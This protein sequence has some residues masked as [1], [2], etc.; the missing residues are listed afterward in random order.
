MSLVVAIAASGCGSSKKTASTAATQSATPTMAAFT[1]SE[2]GKTSKF[3]GPSS[4]KGGLVTV[5][6]TNNGK[7][8]HGAQLIRI[9]GT[10]TIAEAVK[11]VASENNKTPSWL[12]AEGGVGGAPPALSAA[13]TVSLPAGRYAV[14]DFAGGRE[15]QGPP[16]IAQ[17]TVTPGQT[18]AVPSTGTVITAANPSKDHYKWDVSGPLKTGSNTITLV[19]K[20]NSALHELDA[21]RITKDVPIATLVKALE[22]NGPPPSYVDG[23]TNSSTAVID[24]GKSLNTQLIIRKPGK[25]VFIC[26]LTDRDGGKPH[27]AEGLI[28]QVTVK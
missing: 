5:Q 16:A 19:S 25:Y 7:A 22:S 3:T 11:S 13:A 20:G 27:F 8:V 4:V 21:V 28:T 1:V 6:L 15:S 14:V 9:L 17:L 12:R 26:H 2:A 24:G 10:H 23:T 18:A